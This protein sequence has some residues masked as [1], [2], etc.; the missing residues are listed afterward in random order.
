[1]TIASEQAGRNGL[2]VQTDVPGLHLSE[3][4]HGKLLILVLPEADSV[5]RVQNSLLWI[6]LRPKTVREYRVKCKNTI[7]QYV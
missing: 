4:D 5:Q 6:L 2:S 7:I 3:T 1:M